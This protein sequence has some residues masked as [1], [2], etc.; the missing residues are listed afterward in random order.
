MCPDIAAQIAILISAYESSREAQGEMV[1][2][3]ARAARAKIAQEQVTNEGVLYWISR[4][5]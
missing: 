3:L 5:F 2:A 4:D 1:N